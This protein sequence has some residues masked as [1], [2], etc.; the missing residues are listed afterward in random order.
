VLSSQ[1]IVSVGAGTVMVVGTLGEQAI[2][3]RT[4]TNLAGAAM[5][6]RLATALGVDG[7]EAEVAKR[8]AAVGDHPDLPFGTVSTMSELVD[9]LVEEISRSVGFYL[10][11]VGAVAP[12]RV[13]L[14]GAGLALPGL[15]NR[16]V[17]R[18]ELPVVT[19]DLL[20]TLPT[21][22]LGFEPEELAALAPVTPAPIGLAL[23]ARSATKGRIDL[24]SGLTVA[25]A[26]KRTRIKV[27]GGAVAALLLIGAYV[28]HGRS[29]GSEQASVDELRAELAVAAAGAA[30]QN[31]SPGVVGE[32]GARAVVTAAATTDLDWLTVLHHLDAISAP[33]GVQLT[34]RQVSATAPASATAGSGAAAV[35]VS[36]VAAVTTTTAV[37]TA[38]PTVHV[39]GDVQFDATA[40]DLGAVAAW[41]D[42]ITEDDW[43]TD[44][45]V[46]SVT[47]G[48]TDVAFVGH[49]SLTDAARSTR[50]DDLLE[51]A[52]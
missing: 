34:S 38:G 4:I 20:V 31:A 9:E 42:A 35:P 11:Q 10:S 18:L 33:L 5:T 22:D 8:C 1:L 39:A 37:V 44:G 52:P 27:A 28:Q 7:R 48:T 16:L 15:S 23:G 2:F 13:V 24:L 25:A 26:P 43:F 29:L 14:T 19:G 21:R 41:L 6:E 3:S 46:G 17:A 30:A 49:V 45:W 51:V 47:P 40:P 50:L 12:Q 36:N 32:L